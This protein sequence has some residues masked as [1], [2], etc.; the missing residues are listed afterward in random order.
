MNDVVYSLNETG[1][2]VSE[3]TVEERSVTIRIGNEEHNI[4]HAPSY[5]VIN[6]VDKLAVPKLYAFLK[7]QHKLQKDMFD[8]SQEL[9]ETHKE[10]PTK[11]LTDMI[12]MLTK[13]D[14]DKIRKKF[15]KLNILAERAIQV[16][17]AKRRIEDLRPA[18]A[19]FEEQI[20]F[21][22]NNFPEVKDVA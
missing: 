15:D 2:I 4:G 10:D 3:M 18:V 11:Q 1:D 17:D 13:E 16:E 20:Q 14:R 19:K 21:I 8:K 22:E 12:I 5:K 7:E 6:I 9:V